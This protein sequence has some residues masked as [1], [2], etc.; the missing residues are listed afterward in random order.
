MTGT[1]PR[2][3]FLLVSNH[4][5]YVDILLLGGAASGSF[6]AMQE[7]ASWPLVGHLCRTVGTVFIDRS[8]KLDL[9]RVAR[10]VEAAFVPAANFVKPLLTR[11]FPHKG[12][13]YLVVLMRESSPSSPSSPRP[14][15]KR[16]L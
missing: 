14:V 5:S 11:V 6:V 2:A 10:E 16:L 12:S 3:P 1:P 7:I 9:V 8:A 4:L 13:R 15:C